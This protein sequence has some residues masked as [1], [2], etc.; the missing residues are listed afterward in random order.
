M[1]SQDSI[2]VSMMSF[3]FKHGVPLEAD[4]VLDV[5]FLPN[6]HFVEDLRGLTGL[7]AEARSFIE[8]SE[9]FSEYYEKVSSLLL[10]LMPRFIKEGK[11][12]VSVAVGCTGGRHRSVAVAHQLGEQLREEGYRVRTV[13]RDISKA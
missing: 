9:D 10:F 8:S 11:S 1:G 12:Y 4:M 3:G 13:H 7:D 2:F 6:P 5:R